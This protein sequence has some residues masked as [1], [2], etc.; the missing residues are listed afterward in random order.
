M[1]SPGEPKTQ[2]HL[3]IPAA[4]EF[5]EIV[6]GTLGSVAR[7]IGFPEE[8]VEDLKVAASEACNNAIRHTFAE[9][10]GQMVDILL[11]I[12][13]NGL[14]IRIRDDGDHGVHA[15]SR[16]EHPVSLHDRH[17]REI[18][19]S[20]LGTYLME[21]LMDHVRIRYHHGTEVIMIKL[22]DKDRQS[23]DQLLKHLQ[24]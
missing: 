11:E 21:R 9:D 18:N 7:R 4:S 12:G 20:G 24:G 22:L 17:L 19:I 6:R 5:V 23:T 14:S 16:L 10:S 1:L 13:P 2:I 15:F 8:A 3:S